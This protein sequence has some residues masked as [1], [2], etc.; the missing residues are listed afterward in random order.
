MNVLL[1]RT[2]TVVAVFVAIV[3]GALSIEAA[4]AAVRAAAPPP[5]PAVT[6]QSMQAELDAERARSVAL[7]EQ[8]QRLSA[9]STTLTANMALADEQIA[10]DS[11]TADAL[12]AA[13]AKA[14]RQLTRLQRQMAADARR[15]ATGTAA[16]ARPAA[17]RS[18]G[19]DHGHE[20][21]DD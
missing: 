2:M 11:Q 20:E 6:V 14:K 7:H 3:I 4:A 18:G 16:K 17:S 9:Q 13:L 5:G 19:G 21:D 8:L 10:Q 12:R 15:A 1:R